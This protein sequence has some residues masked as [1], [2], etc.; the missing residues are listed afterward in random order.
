MH[1]GEVMPGES[2]LHRRPLALQLLDVVDGL[3]GQRQAKPRHRSDL[4]RQRLNIRHQGVTGADLI[5]HPHLIGPLGAHLVTGEEKF[6]GDAGIQ[7]VGVSKILNAGN[8]HAHNGVREIG[9]VRRHDQIADPCEHKTAG[10]AGALHR[11]DGRLGDFA[12][13]ATHAE[14]RLS[15][16]HIQEFTAF[17]V[18]VVVPHGH[19]ILTQMHIT[20]G[21]ANVVTG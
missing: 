7:L 12:P 14:I 15:L 9:V 1:V 6:L 8:T 17:L 13:A 19:A 4:H 18:R 10:D 3:L 11:S 21:S 20:A 16:T 5:H 2:R